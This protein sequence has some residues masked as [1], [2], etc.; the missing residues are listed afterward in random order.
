MDRRR[1][2]LRLLAIF[3]FIYAGLII[4][5][6]LVPIF[7]LLTASLWWPELASEIER[8]GGD[9]PTFATGALALGFGAF[10]VML[11]W[12]WAGCLIFAGRNL[13]AATRY[14]YCLVIAGIA[15]LSVPVGTALGVTSLVILNREESR[16]V[17]EDEAS[18]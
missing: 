9:M 2:H 5:G 7:W 12:I 10:G 16:Q 18:V 14:T 13:L 8:E 4:V 17:F 11:G 3:H 1:E 15:C 6:T